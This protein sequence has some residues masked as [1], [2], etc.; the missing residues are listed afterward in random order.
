LLQENGELTPRP[1][2]GRPPTIDIDLLK[3]TVD[4]APDS[5]LRELA[6]PF[7]VST[8]AVFYALRKMNYT[9]KKNTRL[10]GK[11]RWMKERKAYQERLDTIHIENLVFVDECGIDRELQREKGAHGTRHTGQ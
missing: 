5:Y 6:E 3:E 1:I 2:P 9:L 11:I 10:P 7:G 4:K 8:M